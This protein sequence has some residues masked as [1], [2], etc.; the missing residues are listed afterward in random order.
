MDELKS[1]RRIEKLI[2]AIAKMLKKDSKKSLE[3][4]GGKI[5]EEYGSLEDFYYDLKDEGPEIINELDIPKE[6]KKELYSKL[7]EQLESQ[8]I[9]ISREIKLSSFEGDGVERIKKVFNE[10]EK[11]AK[12]EKIDLSVCYISAPKYSL[13]VVAKNYKEAESFIEKL[14][15]KTIDLCE[16]EKVKLSLPGDSNE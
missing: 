15:E 3:K 14:F 6:W 9:K 4:I 2:E 16:K 7:S 12:K 10:M 8:K 5:I 11:F 13:D 1:E